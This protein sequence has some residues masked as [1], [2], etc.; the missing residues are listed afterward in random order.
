LAPSPETGLSVG[1]L[2]N[3]GTDGIP[4]VKNTDPERDNAV[5]WKS[6]TAQPL[7]LGPPAPPHTIAG[8]VDVND[9]GQAAGMSA[10]LTN[11]GFSLSAPRIWRTGWTTLKPLRSR[12]P[13]GRARSSSPT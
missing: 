1:Y 13:H 4:G 12:R 2:G 8:L 7:L 6:R 5:V 11:T 3:L 10:T 9:K